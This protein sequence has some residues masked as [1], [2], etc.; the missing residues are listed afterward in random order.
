MFA[1]SLSRDFSLQTQLGGGEGIEGIYG[2][3]TGSHMQRILESMKARCGLGP[4]SCLV[5]VGAGLGRP[6]LHAAVTEALAGAWG[7]ELD[8]VKCV[9]AEAFLRCTAARAVARG[10]APPSL[11][12]PQIRRAPI[13]ALHTL[14][15]A[16]HVYSFWEGIPGDARAAFGRLVAASST[17]VSVTVVQRAMRCPD[18]AAVMDAEYGFG[19]LRLVDRLTVAMSGSGGI[20]QAYV[21]SRRPVAESLS[22]QVDAEDDGILEMVEVVPVVDLTGDRCDIG[23]VDGGEVVDLT[24]GDDDDVAIPR[25]PQRFC[26]V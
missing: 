24:A 22:G 10:L 2:S 4:R 16:T 5:D 18:P 17:I 15:P 19:S 6:L 20:F 25:T 13:E 1:N 7:V 14:D 11:T 8:P 21:F 9:K 12:P 26:W 23:A 3:I